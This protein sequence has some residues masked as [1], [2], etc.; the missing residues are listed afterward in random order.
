[1]DNRPES[2]DYDQVQE[3]LAR[4]D[5]HAGASEAHGMLCG[6]LC[7]EREVKRRW[8]GM[9]LEETEGGDVLRQECQRVLESL[10]A[11]TVRELN[12]EELSFQ[13]L[14]PDDERPLPERVECLSLWCQGFLMGFSAVG[15]K[16]LDELPE[17][18]AEALK[19]IV[20]FT[21]LVTGF[22]EE[23]GNEEEVSYAELVEYLR[24]AVLL[25]REEMLGRRMQPTLH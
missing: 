8:F 5:A 4:C 18:A 24:V 12:D 17:E 10:Y 11:R 1:M 3:Q 23:P 14:L 19:D 6:L 16:G 15:P 2:V 25:I 22:E 7:V 9:L 13:P 21:R 20:E